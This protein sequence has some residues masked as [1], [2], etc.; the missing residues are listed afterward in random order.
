MHGF[1]HRLV[2]GEV[3]DP[4]DVLIVL[5]YRIGVVE[6]AQVHFVILDLLAH[7]LLHAFHQADG[8]TGII[9]LDALDNDPWPTIPVKKDD[10]RALAAALGTLGLIILALFELRLS[11]SFFWSAAS[12]GPVMAAAKIAA[13]AVVMSLFMAS[14][15]VDFC[16]SLRL[17]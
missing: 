7:D 11:G 3:N 12:T 8:G 15:L 4:G 9:D 17:V 2:C 5:K 13:T 10:L 14:F 1:L 16:V 6:V